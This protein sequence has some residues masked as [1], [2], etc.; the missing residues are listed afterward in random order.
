MNNNLSVYRIL[1]YS[2]FPSALSI[3]YSLVFLYLLL[4][5]S[6]IGLIG[7]NMVGNIGNMLLLSDAFEDFLFILM[8][9]NFTTIYLCIHLF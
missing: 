4:L 6:L 1:G 2:Y 8:F 9:Y 3:Y 7:H 5:M